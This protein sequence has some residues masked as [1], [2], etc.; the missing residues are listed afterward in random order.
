MRLEIHDKF[1]TF[2]INFSSSGLISRREIVIHHIM[3][4]GIENRNT[5]S[6]LTAMGMSGAWT[7]KW[8]WTMHVDGVLGN[9]GL[10]FK[11]WLEL[12]KV[13]LVCKVYGDYRKPINLR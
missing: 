3:L 12:Y 11:I 1:L 10:E 5:M 6:R 7:I 9:Y 4:Q 8:V 2:V 13:C